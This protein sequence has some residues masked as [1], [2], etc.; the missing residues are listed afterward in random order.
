MKSP[1]LRLY[2]NH[3]ILLYFLLLTCA[4]ALSLPPDWENPG[5]IG[6]NKESAHC[7]MIPFPDIPSAL[8]GTRGDSIYHKSLNWDWKFYWSAKPS[9]RPRDFYKVD[10][11]SSGWDKIQVP[12]SWQLQGYGIPIYTNVQYSFMPFEEHSIFEPEYVELGKALPPA[13]PHDNNPVG[14][15]ITKFL[16]F[17][18]TGQVGKYSFTLMG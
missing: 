4:T 5:V 8:K 14:S 13:I 16:Q 3:C 17:R 12:S 6:L 18:P 15:Y 9:E 7:T 2:K 1:E 11:N 10:Y